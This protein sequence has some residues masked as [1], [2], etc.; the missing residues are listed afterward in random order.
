MAQRVLNT[1]D[2][3]N[4]ASLLKQFYG[5]ETLNLVTKAGINL[6]DFFE[7]SDPDTQCD[8]IIGKCRPQIVVPPAPDPNGDWAVPEPPSC[9]AD[10]D[11]GKGS[12]W[13]GK[14]I[15]KISP[16]AQQTYN[17]CCYICG[18]PITQIKSWFDDSSGKRK[19]HP[20]PLGQRCEHLLPVMQA[21][22]VFGALFHST[23][24]KRSPYP[25]PLMKRF[26]DEYRWSHHI[27]NK[28]KNNKM[29]IKR[30]SAPEATQEAVD[31]ARGLGEPITS[32]KMD[33]SDK[34]IAEAR[35][36]ARPVEMMVLASE[37]T[38]EE[39]DMGID[40]GIPK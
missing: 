2:D 36:A 31:A 26:L 24:H 16:R 38:K 34:E 3:T 33:V 11:I 6:R 39:T 4:Q 35:E 10:D 13:P 15:Q 8:N 25:D 23:T 27:C 32:E 22:F 9:P 28:I 40:R 18:F 30:S 21:N 29:F 5:K 20:N 19:S 7:G 14:E 17:C 12:P 37:P 1:I